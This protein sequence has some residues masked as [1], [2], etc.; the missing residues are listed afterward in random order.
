MSACDLF[1]YIINEVYLYLHIEQ[2]LDC[3]YHLVWLVG[4]QISFRI[5]EDYRQLTADYTIMQYFSSAHVKVQAKLIR[6]FMIEVSI[7]AL[8][9]KLVMLPT[10]ISFSDIL[11]QNAVD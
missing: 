11:L 4:E 8:L 5:T 6:A 10:P 9:I 1:Y 2:I 3:N 7:L